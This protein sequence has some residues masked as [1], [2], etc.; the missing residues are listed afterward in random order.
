MAYYVV[1]QVIFH[2][3][4]GAG[5]R[6]ALG[7]DLRGKASPVLYVCGIA[8]AFVSPW[9]AILVFTVVAVMWLVPDRRV[10]KYL[11]TRE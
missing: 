10:K 11:A 2:A 5:L 8:L 3:E 7:R 1:Q 6:Q 4:G 9:L